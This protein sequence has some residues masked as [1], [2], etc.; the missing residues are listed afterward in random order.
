MGPFVPFIPSLTAGPA[1]S[2]ASGSAPYVTF[3]RSPQPAGSR[4][5]EESTPS[6]VRA[7]REVGARKFALSNPH[8]RRLVWREPAY[9]LFRGSASPMAGG[10]LPRRSLA[11]LPRAEPRGDTF[12]GNENKPLRAFSNRKSN[13]SRKLATLSDPTTS[14]FLIATKTHFSE[15]KAKSEEKAKTS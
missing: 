1:P 10:S 12:G 3:E 8:T 4:L 9:Q 11:G 15:Q 5:R 2:A 7:T 13:D 6:S 14:E